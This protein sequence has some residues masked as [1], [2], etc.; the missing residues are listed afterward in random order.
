MNPSLSDFT[1]QFWETIGYAPSQKLPDSE[2]ENIDD[3]LVVQVGVS[4]PKLP[5][6]EKVEN[7]GGVTLKWFPKGADEGDI[8]S[9]LISHGLPEN[10]QNILFKPNGQVVI[11][12]LSADICKLLSDSINGK[13][14]KDRRAIYCNP[15]VPV[16]PEKEEQGPIRD[17]S[18]IIN[19]S[20]SS[21][22]K[23]PATYQYCLNNTWEGYNPR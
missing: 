8:K 19:N 7:W 9:F 6:R 14:Y 1:K 12:H 2:M 20:Q 18:R 16:T 3:D 13:K 10:H 23:S 4:T 11:E 17:T 5:P 15:Y 22:K 21:Q